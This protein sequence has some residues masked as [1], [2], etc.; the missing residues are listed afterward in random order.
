M[1]LGVLLGWWSGQDANWDVRNYHLYNPFM[2]L[3]DR[4]E[5]DVHVA[6]VQTFLNPILHLPFYFAIKFE[7]PPIVYGL[8]LSGVHGVLLFLVHRITTLIL[9]AHGSL[10]ATAGGALAAITS[11]FG[12]A[13]YAEIGTT[14]GDNTVG[15]LELGALALVMANA[16]ACRVSMVRA[17]R[18]A[19]LVVGLAA[20][21]KLVASVY[22]VG[23]LGAV[24]M[25]PGTP[26][27]RL[28]RALHFGLTVALGVAVTGGYW[29]WLMYKHFDSPFF[30]FFNAV[31]A[32]PLAPPQN[33]SDAF[34]PGTWQATLEFPFY[35]FAD[36]LVAAETYFRDA[37]LPVALLALATM[38]LVGTRR[39][40]SGGG[41]TASV[42]D[43]RMR[44]LA[45]FFV[46][47]Y[48]VWLAVFALY[49]YAISLE[50]LSGVLIVSCGVY[51]ARSRVEG[52][53]LALPICA[54]LILSTKPLQYGRI[55]WRDSFFGVSSHRFTQYHD[56]V[57]LLSDFPN[58]YTVPFFPPSTTFL[59]I[60]S[61]WGLEPGNQMWRRLQER[62]AAAPSKRLYWMEIAPYAT[63]AEADSLLAPFNVTLQQSACEES[64][65]NFDSLRICQ[66]ERK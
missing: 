36:Q 12:A 60:S 21:A 27:A 53:L 49:R 26:R 14:L 59:R 46:V 42:A 24:L 18:L 13:M 41:T 61:N 1:G 9:A 5:R 66:V 44:Q 45:A 35:F 64:K 29:M 7:V 11:A 43:V 4:F 56:A 47:S 62:V 6:G 15:L 30:P 2:F 28:H 3:D 39:W 48:V 50:A 17:S 40:L 65:T 57:V 34:R 25:M 10:L 32:S 33:F 52:L 54:M 55:P 8:A 37:R 22:I 20:G 51:L 23:I 58:A 38:G 19:G 63:Q 16:T 31:F